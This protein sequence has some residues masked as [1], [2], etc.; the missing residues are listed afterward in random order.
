MKTYTR[1]KFVRPESWRLKRLKPAWRI[2]RGKSN[3]VRRSKEGWPPIVKIGYSRPS[4]IRGLHPSGLKDIIIYR[5]QDLEKINPK[6]EAARIAHVV[7]ENKRLL[8]IEEAQKLGIRVLNPGHKEEKTGA[9]VP[10]PEEAA[11]EAATMEQQKGPADSEP[12]K[13]GEVTK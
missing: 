8:I 13:I 7:G 10:P 3:R 5:P 2:P 4:S 9:E 6:L 11:K 12:K 1:P